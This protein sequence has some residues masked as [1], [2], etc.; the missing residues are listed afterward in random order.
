MRATVI[1]VKEIPPLEHDEA[2]R[3][4]GVEHE[5]LL[6]AVD[7][8][9]GD[10]WRRPTDCTGWDVK[11]VLGHTLGMLEMN[12]DKAEEARQGIAAA[13]RSGR[14]GGTWLD[15]LTANQVDEH[16]H[17]D[18]VELTAALKAAAPKA[19]SG[20]SAATAEEL[21]ATFNPGPPFEGEWTRGYLLD[22]IHTRDRWMHRVDIARATGHE[23]T[24]TPEHDGRIVADVVADWARGHGKAFSLTLDGP[25]GGTFMAGDGGEQ[26]HLDAVEFC[27]ILGGRSHG[28]GLLAHEL[29]F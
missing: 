28:T 6:G 19:L 17:L 13:Q 15:A 27:R 21:A 10:D 16:A 24:V 25:A 9:S 8:L 5:R 14:N 4:A 22:V 7:G 12:A 11:A 29:P 26:L 2:M 23:L 1:S 20:R 3:V 18:P